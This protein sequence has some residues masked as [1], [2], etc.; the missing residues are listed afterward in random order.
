MSSE[1]ATRP[2]EEVDQTARGLATVLESTWS[3]V[4]DEWRYLRMR[5]ARGNPRSPYW[6]PRVG[7]RVK[8]HG[9]GAW[10][11]FDVSIR[12]GEVTLGRPGA[13]ALEWVEPLTPDELAEVYAGRM[14]EASQT[15]SALPPADGEKP[16]DLSDPDVFT[17]DGEVT[18]SPSEPGG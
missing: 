4:V 14:V 5:R 8:L 12:R 7:D 6:V 17:V 18:D 16:V 1:G 9:K 10:L 3:R 2:E 15:P 11:V 13:Q